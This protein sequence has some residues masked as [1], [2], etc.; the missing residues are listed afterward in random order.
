[1]FRQRHA[2]ISLAISAD[3]GRGMNTATPARTYEEA[4]AEQ[5]SASARVIGAG[6]GMNTGNTACNTLKS[7]KLAEVQHI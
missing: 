5:L 4:G 2:S 7:V 1:M 6:C 3:S